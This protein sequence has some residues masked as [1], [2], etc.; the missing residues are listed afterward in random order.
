VPKT[1]VRFIIECCTDAEFAAEISAV[2]RDISAI[3]ISLEIL[4]LT[5][6]GELQQMTEDIFGPYELHDYFLYQWCTTGSARPK[7]FANRY[8]SSTILRW[9]EVFLGDSSVSNSSVPPCLMVPRS[10]RLR[11]PPVAIGAFPVILR[12]KRGW[13]N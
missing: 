3:P 5:P 13:R 10:A 6:D 2:L 1:L 7:S 9:L 8:D 12:L 11:C 4:L